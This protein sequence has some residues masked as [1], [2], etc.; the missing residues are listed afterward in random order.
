MPLH[1][2]NQWQKAF[3]IRLGYAPYYILPC[4][5]VTEL[6]VLGVVGPIVIDKFKLRV[7]K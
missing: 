1:G 5:C 4:P 2:V 3:V 7:I 6:N